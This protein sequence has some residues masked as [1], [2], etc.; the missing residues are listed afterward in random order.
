MTV[1]PSSAAKPLRTWR[2][3]VL[4][5]VAI[6]AA[7]GLAWFVAVVIVPYIQ[8]R[9]IMQHGL[10]AEHVRRLGG[11]E[12]AARKIV[13]YL[14]LPK[15]IAPRGGEGIW[16]LVHLRQQAVPC[17]IQCMKDSGRDVRAVGI[18]LLGQV[19]L[20]SIQRAETES[21]QQGEV[22][23]AEPDMDPRMINRAVVALIDV[24][25]DPASDVHWFAADALGWIGSR[26][27]PAVPALER[28]ASDSTL[29]QEM[30]AAAT[31]ALKKIRGEEPP[32]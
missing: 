32:K 11:P 8:L 28:M 5:T 2:P 12:K 10:G 15:S 14:R 23:K 27:S 26:A 24:L 13:W 9:A 30:R 31:E 4:G 1:P 18:Y 25:D 17:L 29:S 19:I 7:L 22:E 6:L 20:E 16:A 3:M 21:L